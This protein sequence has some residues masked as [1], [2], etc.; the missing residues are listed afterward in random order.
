[1]MV[2]RAILRLPRHYSVWSKLEQMCHVA[3]FGN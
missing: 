3:E 1:L 2:I